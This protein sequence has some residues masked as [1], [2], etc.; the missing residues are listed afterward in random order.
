MKNTT[1]IMATGIVVFLLA[2]T[3]CDS[4]PFGVNDRAIVGDYELYRFPENEKF[5]LHDRTLSN[6]G[7]GGVIDGTITRLGWSEKHIV[8]WRKPLSA[9]DPS[10]WMVVNVATKEITG[11]LLGKDIS[12]KRVNGINVKDVEK[13]WMQLE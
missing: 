9:G 2:L 8:V 11:P 3:A 12:V 5:Y 13:A 1:Q 10:G 4:D 7:G 6:N